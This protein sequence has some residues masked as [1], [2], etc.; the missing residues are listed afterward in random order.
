MS[1]RESNEIDHGRRLAEYDA[2]RAWGWATVAGQIRARRRGKLI[3]QGAN[4]SP[5]QRALEI[6]CGTGLFTKIFAAS[7]AQIVAVDISGELLKVAEQRGLDANQVRFCQASFE[8]CSIDGPF[9]AVIGSSVLHHLHVEASLKKIFDLL[10]NGGVISF[11][12]PNFLNPQIFLERT[13][14][15]LPIFWYVSPDE[16]AFV[17]NRLGRLLT[18]IGFLDVHIDPFDWL[19]PAIPRWLIG[20]INGVGRLLEKTPLV[21]RLAGSL[22]I[23]A[24]RPQ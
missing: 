11:A 13:F 18:A 17:A 8:N 23:V 15:S 2:E 16:T 22:H 3:T 5:G 21:R 12:E 1:S 9:D 7:G 19:H 20:P 10:K 6:G 4:L 24:R 14:S